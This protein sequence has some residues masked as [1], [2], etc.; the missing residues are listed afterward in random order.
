MRSL[1]PA[2]SSSLI[3][4]TL[5]A[6]AHPHPWSTRGARLVHGLY[7]R[8]RGVSNSSCA[9]VIAS[10]ACRRSIAA[11]ISAVFGAAWQDRYKRLAQRR[12]D[13]SIRTADGCLVVA[14]GRLPTVRDITNPILLGVHRAASA[15]VS[16]DGG[17]Q[18]A[19]HVPAYVPRDVN[20]GLR[21]RLAAG[22][23][24]L[25]V[26]DSAAGKSRAAFEA[27]AA[28]LPGHLLVCPS[29]RDAAAVAVARAVQARQSVLWLDDLERY[30]GTGGLTAAQVGRLTA[31][32][33]ATGS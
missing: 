21:E 4:W 7:R 33:E 15:S 22:G 27:V 8:T 23:F 9:Q 13:E 30:L 2:A 6:A 16:P 25:L 31:G 19:E 14:D 12:D 18:A 26:G 29:G 3:F 1:E 5:H 24:V 10:S 32:P 11:R 28:T 17:R 20:A